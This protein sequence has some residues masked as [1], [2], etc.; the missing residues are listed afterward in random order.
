M[1]VFVPAAAAAFFI[2]VFTVAAEEAAAVG[3]ADL[4]LV[5]PNMYCRWRCGDTEGN[6]APK[7]I[8]IS[9]NFLMCQADR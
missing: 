7:S 5:L 6:G 4:L 2:A 9:R 1:A 3:A 8:L